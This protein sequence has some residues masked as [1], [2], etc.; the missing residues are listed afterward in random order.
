MSRAFNTLFG[1][2]FKWQ[3]LPE[4]FDLWADG[5]DIVVFEEFGAGRAALHLADEV[6]RNELLK[7]EAYRRRFRKDYEAK[8]TPRV[9]QRSF[10]DAFIVECPD[11]SVV[12]RSFGDVATERKIHP[13]DAFL[14]LVVEHGKNLRWRTLI[15]N[16]R[17][18]EIATLNTRP[19]RDP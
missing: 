15:A 19:A 8:F 4:V 3:A 16:D 17:P 1:A 13:V 7:D 14:D 9:W 11:E 2:D 12:G 10:H 18:D 5:I 6:A